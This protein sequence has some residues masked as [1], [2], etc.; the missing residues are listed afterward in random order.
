MVIPPGYYAGA[1]KADNMEAVKQYIVDVS[2][3]SPVPLSVFERLL[4]RKV[5]ISSRIVYNFPAVSAGIDMDFDFVIDMVKSAPN[6]CG[7]KFR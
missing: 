7:M 1:L 3:A 6:V 5:L 4:F 2:E